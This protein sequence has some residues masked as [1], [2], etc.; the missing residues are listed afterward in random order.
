MSPDLLTQLGERRSVI[1]DGWERLLR[2]E[3]VTSPLADP[4]T[5]VH[6]IPES[7]STILRS[8]VRRREPLMTLEQAHAISLPVCGCNRNPYVAYF[9]AGERAILEEVILLE[10]KLP[11]RL[12]NRQDAAD[13][14]QVVRRLAA[15]EIETFCSVCTCRAASPE[16]RFYAAAR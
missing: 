4:D 5:L 13:V 16:C 7:L 8:L 11:A 6:L 3:P 15:D 1:R 10:S 9:T 2:L 12:R 14:V